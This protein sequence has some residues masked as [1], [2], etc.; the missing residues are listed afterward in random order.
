MVQLQMAILAIVLGLVAAAKDLFAAATQ[1]IESALDGSG[2]VGE[3]VRSES[4]RVNPEQG[5]RLAWA[6]GVIVAA[7][8]VLGAPDTARAG[9][10]S[11]SGGSCT[12]KWQCASFCA[13]KNCTD[14]FYCSTD[15]NECDCYGWHD[16]D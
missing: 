1:G 16:D 12:A 4:G 7:M 15:R 13:S 11:A 5:F 6:A 10:C 3:F 14:E 9:R 2:F 8:V